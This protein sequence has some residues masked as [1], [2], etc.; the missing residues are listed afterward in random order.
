MRDT[1]AYKNNDIALSEVI[2]FVL[3]IALIVIIASLYLTYGV[4]AQGREAEIL[5]MNDIKDQFVS[6]KLSLDSLFNNNKVGTSV[7]NS[8]TP[9]TPGGYSQGMMSFIPILSPVA[10]SGVVAINDRTND[11]V[12]TI[13]SQSLIVDPNLSDTKNLPASVPTPVNNTPRNLYCNLTIPAATDLTSA[14]YGM[15]VNGNSWRATV[16]LT[17][18]MTFYQWYKS[19]IPPAGS[20]SNVC[21]GGTP[22]LNQNGTALNVYTGTQSSTVYACLVPINAQKYANSAITLSVIKGSTTTLDDTVVFTN[23]TAGR[24]Y[25][26]DLMDNAY[27]L[28]SAMS[29]PDTITLKNSY[30]KNSGSITGSGNVTYGYRETT[31]IMPPLK[32]GSLEY[33]AQNNYWIPQ[34]YYYQ[35]GGVFLAQYDGNITWKLPPEISVANDTAN[36]NI[37]VVNINALAFDSSSQGMI[38]GNSPVQIRTSLNRV[39]QLPYAPV[40]PGSGNTKWIRIAVNTTD[41]QSRIMWQNYFNYLVKTNGIPNAAGGYIG[42]ESYML[43]NGADP[44]LTSYDLNVIAW[45]ASYSPTV[46]GV[47]GIV[48]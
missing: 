13:T 47:G 20:G 23:I 27:G 32:L 11:E 6:Y 38:G 5:H 8:F 28:N 25:A 18:Q 12:L 3:I 45:N 15:E 22:D 16:N 37:A 19:V 1:T 36:A 21:T 34:T 35:M 40:S 42:N 4:P 41:T 43:I 17:P 31:Y 33:R 30:S 9:G 7:S 24:T 2:G 39:S 14:N 26:V 48:Q 10:S 46:Q 44:G 29:Y